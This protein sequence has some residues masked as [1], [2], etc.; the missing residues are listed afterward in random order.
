MQAQLPEFEVR[1]AMRYGE[2]AIAATLRALQAHGLQRLLVLPLYPQYS[3][4]TVASRARRGRAPSWRGWRR[5]PSCAAINDYHLDDAWLDAL[6]ASVQN[7]WD[8]HGRGERLLLSFHGLPQRM[9]AAGDPYA[10]AVRGRRAGAGATAAAG[11]TTQ[12]QLTFQSRFGREPLAA[13]LHRRERWRRWRAQGVRHVDVLCPG[14]A[15]DCLE[16]LEEIAVENAAGL[17]RRRRRALRY[18]PALNASARPCRRAG[19]AGAPARLGLAALSE[20]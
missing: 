7:H 5:R 6:A 17:P 16:T 9:V 20:R 1:L 12:W 2:P 11:A 3:A 18:I 13:A 4:S 14:F 10:R 19:G 15:V 8:L